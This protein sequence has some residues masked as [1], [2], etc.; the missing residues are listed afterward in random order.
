MLSAVVPLTPNTTP[1]LG[2]VNS[3]PVQHSTRLPMIIAASDFVSRRAEPR[4]SFVS[5]ILVAWLLWPLSFQFRWACRFENPT[6]NR[7][8]RC[9]Q[10]CPAVSPILQSHFLSFWCFKSH[11][12]RLQRPTVVR[13]DLYE[14]RLGAAPPSVHSKRQ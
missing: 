10:L 6:T 2:L 5:L 9:I 13:D 1:R 14:T 12:S 11:F 7:P 8:E 4:T 3:A